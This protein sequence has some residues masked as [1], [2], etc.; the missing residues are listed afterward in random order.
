MQ[1]AVSE[2]L[3]SGWLAIDDGAEVAGR[4]IP[5]A[6]LERGVRVAAGAQVGSL[7]VLGEDVSSARARRSS[8]RWSSTARR[9]ASAA[10][11]A[12]ASSRPAVAIGDGTTVTGGA[13]LGE[14][15][16]RRGGQRDRPR[17]AY[18]PGCG[19]ARRRDQVLAI[20]PASDR[21]GLRQAR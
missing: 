16:T 9:S 18:L 8:A 7:V 15:V 19:V 12:T 3:G 2:R 6:V 14:G 5:P 13:V 17:G 4:V 11:C 20:G 1:T 10:G 21:D